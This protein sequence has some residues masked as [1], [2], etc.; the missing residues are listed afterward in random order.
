MNNAKQISESI[1]KDAAT[2]LMSGVLQKNVKRHIESQ[3]IP[4]ELADKIMKLA[5]V[6]ANNYSH[7]KIGKYSKQY[8]NK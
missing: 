2:R 6:E 8:T 5:V 7:Y 4:S 1:I 3:G